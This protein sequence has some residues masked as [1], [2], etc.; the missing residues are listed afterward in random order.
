MGNSSRGIFMV[1]PRFAT[2]IQKIRLFLFLSAGG[3]AIPGGKDKSGGL[4]V[5]K[6]GDLGVSNFFVESIQM[7]WLTLTFLQLRFR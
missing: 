5:T 6:K 7:Y 3:G 2:K 4:C 1:I